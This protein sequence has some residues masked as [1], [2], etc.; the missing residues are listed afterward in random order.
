MSLILD[1]DDAIDGTEIQ[2]CEDLTSAFP[3]RRVGFVCHGSA[4]SVIDVCQIF[5]WLSTAL[6]TSQSDTGVATCT[7][8][9]Y[10]QQYA[11]I[12]GDHT[13]KCQLRFEYGAE[14]LQDYNSLGQCW[15]NMFRNPVIA[16]G[17]PVH[18][19]QALQVGLEM[20]LPVMSAL[21]RTRHV[22]LFD[23]N[24]MIKSHSAMLIITKIVG[25]LMMWHY[26]FERSGEYLPL[27]DGVVESTGGFMLSDLESRRHIIGWCSES[28][29]YT[30]MSSRD[31]TTFQ[32]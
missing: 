20:S 7:P 12:S 6:R 24:L 11:M 27:L 14:L 9:M 26:K 30:G 28:D 23:S 18:R 4:D 1:L 25:E 10:D 3:M 32:L 19:R 21:L 16:F 31:T 17:F 29:Y 22:Q 8:Y 15:T 13:L 2:I 5:A